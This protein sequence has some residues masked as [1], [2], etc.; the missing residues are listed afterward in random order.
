MSAGPSEKAAIRIRTAAE[1][2][3]PCAPIRDLVP[4]DDTDAAYAVQDLNTTH[5]LSQGATLVGRKIGLTS[6]A[7]QKQLGVD[8]PDYGMLFADKSV[9]SGDEIAIAHLLQ[10]RVEAEIAFVLG[11]DLDAEGLTTIDLINAIDYVLPAIEVV[12]SRINDW[13]IT[14]ADTIADNASSGMF[15]LG[16]SP[17]G[18]SEFDLRLC[19]MVMERRGEVVSTGAGAACLGNPLIATRWL[20]EVMAAAGRPL[21]SGDVVLSG[22]LGPMVSVQ[23]GDVFEARISGLGG[24]SAVFSSA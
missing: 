4:N 10:P 13:D 23:P 16:D 14:I 7:I 15:V 9:T 12:D 11:D 6:A 5:R 18:L 22:G 3:T 24:V 2:A 21:C 17:R 1:T 19:G 20:A 8:Q